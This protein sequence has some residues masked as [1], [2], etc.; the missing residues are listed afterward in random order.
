MKKVLTTAF[1]AFFCCSLFAQNQMDENL[2]LFEQ[3]ILITSAGQ[4]AEVQLASVLAKRAGLEATLSKLA[5]AEE[6]ENIKTVALVIGASL[7]GMG[8]A[9]L[10]VSEEKKRVNL[11]M[12]KAQEKRIPILCL[13]LGG[14]TRRGQLSDEFI[15]AFLPY[16]QMAFVLKSGNKDGLFT[17]ICGENNIPLIEVDKT[18]DV[19]EPLRQAFK[20]DQT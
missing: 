1:I 20:R 19:L 3:P 12:E 14:E 6:L 4:S 2:L 5:T 9:G 18:I 16:A 8:T 11:L 13:H 15:T 17:T 10:D 7:K